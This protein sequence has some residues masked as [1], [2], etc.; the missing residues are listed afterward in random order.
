MHYHRNRIIQTN[1]TR[2]ESRRLL[3]AATHETIHCCLFPGP[4]PKL[5]IS[6][7][8]YEFLT[9]DGQLK[10]ENVQAHLR[11]TA[12]TEVWIDDG[13]MGLPRRQKRQT[14]KDRRRIK[15]REI[16][17]KR[18]IRIVNPQLLKRGH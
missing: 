15:W 17:A 11:V 7:K 2:A 5:L 12:G 4:P 3:D 14:A 6:R 10:P 18:L 16:R 8:M 1:E 13:I 9:V